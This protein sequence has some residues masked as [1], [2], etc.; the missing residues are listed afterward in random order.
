[1]KAT[2]FDQIY[3]IISTFPQKLIDP[4]VLCSQLMEKKLKLT[5]STLIRLREQVR[6]EIIFDLQDN[7]KK[8]LKF[9]QNTTNFRLKYLNQF[10]LF[11]GLNK[12]YEYLKKQ[13]ESGLA[14]YSEE[15][16]A[17]VKKCLGVL[18]SNLENRESDLMKVFNCDPNWPV[19]LYDFSY[20]NKSNQFQTLKCKNKL[21]SYVV[22]NYFYEDIKPAAGKFSWLTSQK[23]KKSAMK[24]YPAQPRLID[25]NDVVREQ[26]VHMCCNEGG[27]ELATTFIRNFK[28][29]YIKGE[30]LLFKN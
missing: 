15:Q 3:S 13:E 9:I 21:S 1:M 27:K 18:S 24:A 7:F 23:G 22:S 14:K 28:I 11:N 8:S 26:T 17:Y 16:S 12:Y 4:S 25:P 19:C 2:A 10:Y 20:K 6:P 29:L 5:N 30:D